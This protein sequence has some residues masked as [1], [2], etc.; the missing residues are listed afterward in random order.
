[1]LAV[2]HCSQPLPT[3]PRGN[4]HQHD[5]ACVI[6]TP[7]GSPHRACL[8]PEGPLSPHPTHPPP[9]TQK[10]KKTKFTAS[11]ATPFTSRYV[12]SSSLHSTLSTCIT[13]YFHFHIVPHAR[14][15]SS[16]KISYTTTTD[17]EP[18]R[19]QDDDNDNDEDQHDVPGQRISSPDYVD[20]EI[21]QSIGA[22]VAAQANSPPCPPQARA[23]PS[24]S[25]NG[26]RPPRQAQPSTRSAQQ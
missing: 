20:I 18:R 16:S 4:P 23:T 26:T 21:P 15:S 6:P 24:G 19:Q 11:V 17:A 3:L 1:M 2:L 14:L 8:T 12:I 7:S 9:P 22:G 13:Y 25:P 10:K 5:A